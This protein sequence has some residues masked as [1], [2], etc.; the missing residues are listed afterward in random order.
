MSIFYTYIIYTKENK[1]YSLG[2][3]S[4]MERRLKL[5][6]SKNKKNTKLVYWESYENSSEATEREN[7]LQK[8]HPEILHQLV[9]ENNPALTDLY[10]LI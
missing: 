1:F 3:T 6:K 4:D 7:I 10:N 2:V 9:K 5:L 8:F